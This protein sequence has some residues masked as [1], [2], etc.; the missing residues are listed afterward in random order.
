MSR[1]RTRQN[2]IRKQ[3]LEQSVPTG[4]AREASC[5]L[6]V[7]G[8]RLEWSSPCHYVLGISETSGPF[9]PMMTVCLK[10]N[11]GRVSS[12]CLIVS[13]V[14]IW[15]TLPSFYLVQNEEF[16]C[17]NLGHLK[18]VGRQDF[19]TMLVRSAVSA[20]CHKQPTEAG[21]TQ[22]LPSSIFQTL[23]ILVPPK[24]FCSGKVSFQKAKFFSEWI[25]MM[26]AVGNIRKARGEE[27]KMPCTKT[28]KGCGECFFGEALNNASS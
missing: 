9:V 13:F 10:K 1:L 27:V 7:R 18:R 17:W 16:H 11:Q 22:R 5:V 12:R 25:N 15:K 19:W 21:L 3:E 26:A 2:A 4:K 14:C 20:N 23:L 24:I 8:I 28:K 6:S